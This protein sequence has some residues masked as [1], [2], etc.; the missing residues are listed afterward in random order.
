MGGEGGRRG[1]VRVGGGERK[2][3][4]VG[5]VEEML[6]CLFFLLFMRNPQH[7]F[8]QLPGMRDEGWDE[9][10]DGTG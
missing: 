10:W 3:G 8:F 9:G 2:G 5:E 6:Q 7:Y 4:W 1:C